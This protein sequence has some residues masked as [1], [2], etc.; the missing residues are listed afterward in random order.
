M[1]NKLKTKIKYYY[2]VIIKSFKIL[3]YPDSYL[4]VTGFLNS[5]GQNK[6]CDL[7]GNPIPWMNYNALSFL[8]KRLNKDITL[9]EYGS[10]YSTTFYANLV[11]KVISVE[12]DKTWLDKI[13]NTLPDNASLIFKP[14]DYEGDYCHAILSTSMLFDVVIIDGRDRVRCAKNAVKALT[15][16]GV[17]IFDDSQREKYQEGFDF[18]IEQGFKQLDF[19][20]L[21]PNNH[22]LF[23]TSIFY[24]NNNCLTL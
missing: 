22:K 10:G 12:Y 9:F 13:Q 2:L 1:V 21:K 23:R 6:P 17:I 16:R 5:V 3:F 7:E 4:H 24:K 20:G 14:L 8:Q 18:L 15:D 19:E 11:S